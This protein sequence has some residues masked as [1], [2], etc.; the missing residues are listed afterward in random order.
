VTFVPGEGGIQSKVDGRFE[1]FN[2]ESGF[3]NQITTKR[4]ETG[5][6]VLVGDVSWGDVSDLIETQEILLDNAINYEGTIT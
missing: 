1:H 4:I 6:V 3:D 5:E 2:E